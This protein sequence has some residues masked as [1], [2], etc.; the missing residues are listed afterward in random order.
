MLCCM[1]TPAH[2]DMVRSLH[3]TTLHAVAGWPAIERISHQRGSAPDYDEN[4]GTQCRTSAT[5]QVTLSGAG[6][7][8]GVEVGVGQALILD[9]GAHPNLRYRALRSWEFFY[10]NLV[11]ARPHIEALVAARG[12]VLPFPHRHPVLRHWMARLPVLGD[13]HVTFGF[14]E[15]N[16]LAFELLSL[17]TATPQPE[18]GLVERA[19]TLMAESWDCN[20]TLAEVARSLDISAEHFSRLFHSAVGETPSSWYR[21]NRMQHARELLRHS[22]QSIAEI[23]ARCGFNSPA[24]FTASFRAAFGTTPARWRADARMV[25]ATARGSHRTE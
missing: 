14:H 8:D 24:Y 15:S 10:V 9:G 1:S 3:V 11:G 7:A 23:G 20:L 22:D 16:R 13:R 21:H 2:Q 17:L 4:V 6:K 25:P 19:L 12:F 5:I 18:S